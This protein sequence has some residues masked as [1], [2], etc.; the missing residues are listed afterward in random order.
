MTASVASETAVN[1]GSKLIAE[2]REPGPTLHIRLAGKTRTE[3]GLQ[4]AP[5]LFGKTMPKRRKRRAP[6]LA[7]NLICKG[8]AGASESWRTVRL[9]QNSVAADVSR[10]KHLK[11]ARTNVR[12]Y[13]VLK[14]PPLFQISVSLLNAIVCRRHIARMADTS[15]R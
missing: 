2:S 4:P 9:L 10:R 15:S 5:T 1:T 8:P 7:T 12:G 13:E 6:R 3:R 11:L 14:E